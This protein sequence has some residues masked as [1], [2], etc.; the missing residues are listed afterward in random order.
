[1]PAHPFNGKRKPE[2]R[3]E[4]LGAPSPALQKPPDGSSSRTP[5]RDECLRIA[6]I[7]YPS[8][9]ALLP[10]RSAFRRNA[11]AVACTAGGSTSRT[12]ALDAGAAHGRRVHTLAVAHTHARGSDRARASSTV[13]AAAAAV[14]ALTVVAGAPG[15]QAVANPA[16]LT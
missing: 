16:E 12:P 6:A 15:A 11:R 10:A 3:F 13:N 4:V 1:M 2:S 9:P 5:I 8:R 7:L 14:H